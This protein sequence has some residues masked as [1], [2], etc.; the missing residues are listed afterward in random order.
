[1]EKTSFAE[2]E[3]NIDTT[4]T[5]DDRH[6]DPDEVVIGPTKGWQALNVRDLWKHRE[7]LWLLTIRDVKIRYK[8]TVLGVAWTVLQPTMM[9]V[10]FAVF[11]EPMA[12]FSSGDLP[13]TVF[14]YSGLLAWTFFA[15]ATS[16]AANSVVGSEG[17]VKRVYV[18]RLIFPLAAVLSS[19]IDLVVAFTV[20]I[21]LMIY[22]RIVPGWSVVW[23]L[24]MVP[25]LMLAALGVGTLM[26]ALNVRY[27]DFRHVV[28]FLIQVGLFA[29]PAIYDKDL[30]SG[31]AD[32]STASSSTD[33][34][35]S[36]QADQNRTKGVFVKIEARKLQF[37]RLN[38]MN[39]LIAGFRAATLGRPLPWELI[40]PSAVMVVVVF[41]VGCYY[42]RRVEDTFADII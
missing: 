38:P 10:V 9:M 8:Q 3:P 30:L 26:G 24:L 40:A 14:L 42:F 36:E 37:L 2:S 20:L 39:G 21:L 41:V 1:M 33:G 5:K 18:P 4:A 7:L 28:A 16:K 17:I 23:L 19:L 11:I 15:S 12:N 35:N 32:T 29:T 27:R 22:H 34:A 6:R 31:P 25:L 13:T